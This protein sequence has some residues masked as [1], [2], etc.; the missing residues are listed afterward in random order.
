M[1]F[2]ALGFGAQGLGLWGLGS[3]LGVEGAGFRVQGLGFRAVRVLGFR[4]FERRRAWTGLFEE[5]FRVRLCLRSLVL[6]FRCA[7]F[8][9]VGRRAE[10]L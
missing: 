3:G 5:A 6:L 4:A 8:E 2:R 9:L 10:S 7:L 1:G